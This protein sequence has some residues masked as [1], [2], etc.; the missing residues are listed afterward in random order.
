MWSVLEK[1][2]HSLQ[3]PKLDQI[4]SQYAMQKPE[5]YQKL[6]Q[7]LDQILLCVQCRNAEVYQK[8]DQKKKITN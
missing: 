8:L 2:Q 5:V 3:L 4:F 1:N 6:D 7:K